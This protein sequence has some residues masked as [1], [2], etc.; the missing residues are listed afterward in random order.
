MGYAELQVAT[1]FSFL[2]GASHAAELVIRASELG[3]EAIAVTDHNTLAGVVRAHALRCHA[4]N[5]GA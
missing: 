2:R 1:N 3:L 5:R 4:A